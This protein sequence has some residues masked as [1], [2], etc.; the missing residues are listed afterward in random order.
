MKTDCT[1]AQTVVIQFYWIFAA[2]MIK[3]KDGISIY[4]IM[5]YGLR[6]E[7]Q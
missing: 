2:R 7:I 5:V 1:I 6:V 4:D 3:Q